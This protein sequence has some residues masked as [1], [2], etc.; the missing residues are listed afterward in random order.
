MRAPTEQV[1]SISRLIC[2]GCGSETNA[3]CNCGMEYRPKAVR[4]AEA[5][6]ANPEKSD[7]A[8]AA[9]IGVS[10]MTVNRARATVPDV[11]VER[12]G[13]D[14]KTRKRLTEEERQSLLTLYGQG[15][16]RAELA[17]QFDISAATVGNIVNKFALPPVDVENELDDIAGVNIPDAE[18]AREKFT[19]SV[20]S[21]IN[22]AAEMGELINESDI[23]A[24]TLAEFE[25]LVGDLI[26]SWKKIESAIKIKRATVLV[27][28]GQMGD[29][30][31]MRAE[32]DL[33]IPDYLKR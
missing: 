10:P 27:A 28:A 8:I 22:E 31:L 26:Q 29:P 13:L 1:I 19:E 14:G 21:I 24:S 4:A 7:R 5:V 15:T 23:C 11:T 3:T 20:G 17:K 9:D 18:Y 2:V 32:A 25:T 12:T 33:N 6:E 30:C 16:P